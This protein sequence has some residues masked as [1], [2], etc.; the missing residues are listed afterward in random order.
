MVVQLVQVHLA[1]AARHTN[2][3]AKVV[4]GLQVVATQGSNE[5][6]EWLQADARSC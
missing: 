6:G 5:L 2:L 4:Y 3:A 1:L